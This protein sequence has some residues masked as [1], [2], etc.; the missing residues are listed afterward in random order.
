MTLHTNQSSTNTQELHC[1]TNKE[2]IGNHV[3]QLY[4]PVLDNSSIFI[5]LPNIFVVPLSVFPFFAEEAL[6]IKLL[7]QLLWHMVLGVFSQVL[8]PSESHFEVD[9]QMTSVLPDSTISSPYRVVN[10]ITIYPSHHDF[11]MMKL[12]WLTWIR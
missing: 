12:H 7:C 10:T 4:T 2:N 9:H 1:V 5:F 6:N 11:L 8:T 3:Y